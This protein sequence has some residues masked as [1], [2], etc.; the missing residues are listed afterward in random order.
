MHA[1]VMLKN[2]LCVIVG[3]DERYPQQVTLPNLDHVFL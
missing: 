3:P 1:S 2:S